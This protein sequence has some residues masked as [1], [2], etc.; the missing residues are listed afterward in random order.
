MNA[1]II[2]VQKEIVRASHYLS[3][4]AGSE[5]VMYEALQQLARAQLCEKEEERKKENAKILILHLPY[6]SVSKGMKQRI[7]INVTKDLLFVF[8]CLFRSWGVFLF[9]SVGKS[10][11]LVPPNRQG[12]KW[13]GL[14]A[15]LP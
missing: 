11:E 13:D 15:K 3:L 1:K 12:Q 9:G 2:Y 6:I 4:C 10:V 8:S 7:H 5:R 14:A